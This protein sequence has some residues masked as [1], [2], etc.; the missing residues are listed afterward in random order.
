MALDVTFAGVGAAG[1]RDLLDARVLGQ[2]GADFAAAAGQ[3]VEHT[4]RQAGFGE[5]FSQ[6]QGGQRRHF[7]GLENHRVARGQCRSR[8]PQGDLDRVVP[9]ADT[10]HN[11]Q[12][13][14]TGVDER[15]VT[16]RDLLAFNGR[17]QARVVFQYVG[18]GHDVD[19]TGFGVRLAG[20]QGFQCGQFIVALAQ[21]VH[22]TAQ[23]ARTL[24]GGHGGPDL[25]AFF[26][27]DN[28]AFDVFFGRTLHL[29]EDF[30]VSRVDGIEGC[31]AAGVG[32]AAVDVKFLQF[33][34][35]HKILASA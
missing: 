25:L 9:R 27:A 4:V 31:I 22:G 18:A 3:N 15:G 8:F 2:P 21:D 7:A 12:R 29:G 26:S 6:F 1:E 32:V 34:T 14:A 19:V 28:G 17:G 10:G 23:D 5:D 11:A 33:E 16:Q 30:A 35:G 24:H 13:L 20:V